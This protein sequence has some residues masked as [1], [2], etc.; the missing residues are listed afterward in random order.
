MKAVRKTSKKSRKPYRL[1]EQSEWTFELI[2]EIHLEIKRVAESFGLDTYPNQLE[3]I[4][5]EQ[6]MDAYASVG[7]ALPGGFPIKVTYHEYRS[8]VGGRDFG[9]EWNALLTHKFGQAWTALVKYAHYD[10]RPPYYDLDRVWVQTEFT[11]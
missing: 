11:F 1:P 8:D 6:M 4:T 3:I 2:E 7:V 10:G 9:H 5:A